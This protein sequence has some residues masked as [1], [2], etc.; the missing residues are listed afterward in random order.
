MIMEQVFDYPEHDV[1]LNQYIIIE[2]DGTLYVYRNWFQ[3]F[4]PDTIT[5]ELEQGGFSVRHL[6]GDLAGQP[7]SEGSEWIG[8]V[9]Q[10]MGL[11]LQVTQGFI[12]QPLEFL[13]GQIDGAFDR[14]ALLLQVTFNL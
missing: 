13:D 4:T 8:V 11:V 6:E 14:I 10:K 7:Y 5:S 9:A 2:A 12:V 3:S 1:H